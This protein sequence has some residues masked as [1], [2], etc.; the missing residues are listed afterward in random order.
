[1]KYFGKKSLSSFLT[2]FLKIALVLAVIIAFI[3][4][5]VGSFVLL[6]EP[7]TDPNATGFA[8]F[9]Y[10]FFQELK[11]DADYIET[12]GFPFGIRLLFIP[13][14]LAVMTLIIL[15]IKRAQSV[16]ANFRDDIVFNKSNVKIISQLGKLII[17][18]SILT[19]NLAA[20]IVAVLLLFLCRIIDNGTVLKEEQ[21]LT[22]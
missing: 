15:I 6:A 18:L 13:Y 5:T 8:A 17:P 2:V 10:Y 4:I 3:G 12:S 20:F 16:F 7:E 14:M 19:M 21:E 1:M 22:I 11:D 9:N